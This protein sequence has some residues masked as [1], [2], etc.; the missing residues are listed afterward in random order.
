MADL[1]DVTLSA[2]EKSMEGKNLMRAVMRRWLPA[3]DAMLQMISLHLPSPVVAQRYRTELLYEGPLDD[4][5]AIGKDPW[6]EF[7]IRTFHLTQ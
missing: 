4:D 5:A 3:G 2:E 6:C 1:V 7:I